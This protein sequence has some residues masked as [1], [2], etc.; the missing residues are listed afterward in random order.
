M[1]K[2]GI[3]ARQRAII[4]IIAKG[5]KEKPATV[6]EISAQLNLSTRTIIREMPEIEKWLSENHFTLYKK[7][8]VGLLLEESTESIQFLLELLGEKNVVYQYSREERVQLI[9]GEL[10]MAKEPIKSFSFI[11]RFKISDATFSSDLD[12]IQKKLSSYNI[13][14][15]RKQGLGIYV[16]GREEDLRRA[17]ADT[18]YQILDENEMVSILN[19]K[20]TKHIDPNKEMKNKLLQFIDQEIIFKIEEILNNAETTY[21]IKYEDNAYIGL[22]IHL[23]LAVKRIQKSEKIT[24]E[25]HV[26]DQLSVLDQYAVA[27]KIA[28]GLEKCFDIVIPEAEIGYI[29]MHLKGSKIRLHLKQKEWKFSNIKI[30][31]LASRIVSLAEDYLQVNLKAEESLVEDIANHIGPVLNRLQLGLSIKNPQLAE[32]K[33]KYSEV[34]EAAKH[35]CSILERENNIVSIP[36]EEIGFLAMHLGAALIRC[37]YISS[38]INA[39]VVCPSGIGT[40]KLLAVSLMKEFPEVEVKETISAL[41]I[42][43]ESL[44]R[45]NIDLLFST[46]TLDIEYAY[47]KVNPVL[48]ENDKKAIRKQIAKLGGKKKI[49]H[50]ELKEHDME[51][52]KKISLLGLSISDLMEHVGFKILS[53]PKKEDMIVEAGKLFCNGK[54]ETGKEIAK[55]IQQR[56]SISPTYVN[57]LEMYFFH[58][59]TSFV[60]QCRFGIL[61]LQ[62]IL[63][64]NGATIRG[65]VVMLIPQNQRDDTSLM[66]EISGALIENKGFAEAVKQG[67]KPDIIRELEKAV[68][69]FFRKKIKDYFN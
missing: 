46:I 23:S 19:G 17:I 66:S 27:T 61:R 9:L 30:Y 14:L 25:K 22:I 50:P 29:T 59:I 7:P 53:V 37:G 51:N 38:K 47:L 36:E 34:F 56:E 69:K 26:L 40:S 1:K 3:T 64:Q 31:Q 4:E 11:S 68:T 49:I 15:L 5:S 16:E 32:V 33:T 60:Q 21:G 24:M 67:E 52:M 12:D 63:N 55:A 8:G 18:L 43:I 13:T 58:C 45:N 39:V 2:N 28:Q 57:E 35:V 65:A 44:Q 20:M 48:G 62:P 42:D 10:L 54:E 41:N 6:S